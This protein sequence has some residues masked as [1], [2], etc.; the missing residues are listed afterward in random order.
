[1]SSPSQMDVTFAALADPPRRAIVVRLASGEAW[2][3]ELAK[4]FA[5]SQP[6]VSKHLKVL[7]RAG[8]ITRGQDAQRRPRRI[9]GKG[10]GAATEWLQQ[11]REF[12]GG[13]FQ[14]LDDLLEEMKATE[15]KKE[16]SEERRVGKECRSR[17]S[18][19]H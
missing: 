3:K 11:F 14:R 5:M 9:Q 16:R 1:M 19:Y 10:L 15:R 4:P 12:W 18:P 2:V 13:S 6:A 8:L 17:W 7:E